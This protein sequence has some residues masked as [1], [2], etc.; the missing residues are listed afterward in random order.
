MSF[1]CYQHIF[2]EK[3]LCVKRKPEKVV[4]TFN[5]PILSVTRGTV[6]QV[7]GGESETN[8]LADGNRELNREKFGVSVTHSY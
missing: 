6:E 8:Y 7:A 4:S 5:D 3:N 1:E 2:N